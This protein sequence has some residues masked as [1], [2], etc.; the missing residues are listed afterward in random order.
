MRWCPDEGHAA[1]VTLAIGTQLL[2]GERSDPFPATALRL[3]E[4]GRFSDANSVP[5]SDSGSECVVK[6]QPRLPLPQR[7]IH[8]EL[9]LGAVE[10][11]DGVLIDLSQSGYPGGGGGLVPNAAHESEGGVQDR[12]MIPIAR[13][14]TGGLGK[15]EPVHVRST[16]GR[17]RCRLG[18]RRE[19]LNEVNRMGAQVNTGI[20][21][22]AL[23]N[24]DD[25]IVEVHGHGK[26]DASFGYSGVRG[27]NASAVTLRA[28]GGAPV[29]VADALR[30]VRRLRSPCATG[31]VLLR[32][33]SAYFGRPTV[34]AAVKG[35]RQVSVTVRQN[36]LLQRAI[37]SIPD[38]AWS[39]ID[40]PDAVRDWDTGQG[41]FA[42]VIH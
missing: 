32:A 5:G 10:G 39:T 34:L 3:A 9:K 6:S 21:R 31:M 33:D 20:D 23:V 25:T 12:I 16:I 7:R 4:Q 11:K 38:D 27:L 40:Y 29:I 42:H 17:Q 2:Q 13:R 14:G 18:R 28:P 8:E 37:S 19:R 30:T 41:R 1:P 36:T 26:Q 15:G 24:F 22:L 35:G